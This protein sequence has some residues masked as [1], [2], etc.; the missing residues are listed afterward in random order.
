M[1]FDTSNAEININIYIIINIF[2]KMSQA[3][4][5]VIIST[6]FCVLVE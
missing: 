3:D 4:N 1:S 6:I 5:N 2:T